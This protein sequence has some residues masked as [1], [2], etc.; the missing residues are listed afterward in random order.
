METIFIIP[1]EL[2]YSKGLVEL[3]RKKKDVEAT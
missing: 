1:K 2:E 3:T